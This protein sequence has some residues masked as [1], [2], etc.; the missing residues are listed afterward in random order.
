MPEDEAIKCPCCANDVDP[1]EVLHSTQENGDVCSDCYDELWNCDCCGDEHIDDHSRIVDICGEFVCSTCASNEY[2][3]CDASGEYF[4]H[5]REEYYSADGHIVHS[6]YANDYEIDTCCSCGCDIYINEIYSDHWENANQCYDCYNSAEKHISEQSYGTITGKQVGLTKHYRRIGGAE[7]DTRLAKSLYDFKRDFYGSYQSY[8]NSD[9]YLIKSNKGY[10]ADFGWWD[11]HLEVASEHYRVFAGYIRDM[12][13]HNMFIVEHKKY[14]LYHPLRDIFKTAIQYYDKAEGT[15]RKA[16]EISLEAMGSN[17]LRYTL[18]YVS[19]QKIIAMLRENKTEDGANLKKLLSNVFNRSYKNRITGV[20]DNDSSFHR[21]YQTYQ[22]NT[23][24]VELPV[25]IGFD[26]GVLKETHRFNRK[27]GSCQV[28]SNN[29]SYSFGMMDMITNP[30]LFLLIY[31]KEGASII[32]RSIIKFYKHEGGWGDKEAPIYIAPSR[33]YLS[34]YT[35]AKNDVYA[36]MFKAVN[37]FAKETFGDNYIMLCHRYSR[38]DTSIKGILR[39]Q[40]DFKFI[41]MDRDVYSEWWHPYWLE[42]PSSDEADFTYYQDESANANIR[43][44]NG[45]NELNQ[46]FAVHERIRAR[47]I[48]II[49]VI[50]KNN[51]Q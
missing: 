6:D 13:S 41:E 4:N 21:D 14:G 7:T 51:E 49:E 34:E 47:D 50:E 24:N 36:S 35:N 16:S 38:H 9:L 3:V 19:V 15:T 12:I 48:E 30:H 17:W 28:D 32:G 1:D 2:Y 26:A 31:D 37:N 25:R 10:G 20:Y 23:S 39:D 18:D 11:S 40:A 45:L 44:L 8:E 42:K 29:E 27:V 22:T 5:S 46:D 33:L 43:R